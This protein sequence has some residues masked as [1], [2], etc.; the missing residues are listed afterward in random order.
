MRFPISVLRR[1]N[2]D[3]DLDQIHRV[4]M[5]IECGLA[6]RLIG[7]QPPVSAS[8]P[9]HPHPPNPLSG[10]TRAASDHLCHL[11]LVTRCRPAHANG[12]SWPNCAQRWAKF[13]LY[14]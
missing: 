5:L 4:R 14:P 1:L 8:G 2:S 11:M 3:F 13:R 7:P 9:G 12:L 6:P 10:A